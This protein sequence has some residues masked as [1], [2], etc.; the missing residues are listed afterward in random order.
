MVRTIIFALYF[1]LYLLWTI[2]LIVPY[3][4]FKFMGKERFFMEKQA[5]LW[6]RS[7]IW[8]SGSRIEVKGMEHLPSGGVLFVGNHQ[9]NIDILVVL[10]S[11]HRLIGFIAKKELKAIPILS[12]W[13]KNIHCIF[14]D[15]KS[16]RKSAE[17]IQQGVEYLKKGYSLVIFPEG[18][19][20]KSARIGEFKSGSIKLGLL[21][22][23]PI[24]PITL[25]GSYHVWEEKKQIRPALI[26]LTI[27]PPIKTENFS[28]K[29]RDQL[30]VRVKE[31]IASALSGG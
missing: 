1:V 13:M 9:S 26:K 27:H 24:V 31:Q 8:L 4:L 10:S 21:S 18:H 29:D 14:M 12:F 5:M 30:L 7:L 15:R 28:K 17:A 2:V 3:Y 23:V 22:G 11:I 6:G 19:R 16:L 25:D 20:S